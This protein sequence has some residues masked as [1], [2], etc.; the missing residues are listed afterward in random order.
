VIVVVAVAVV[1]ALLVLA[2][3]V[4]RHDRRQGRERRSARLMSQE[5]G[6]AKRDAR[7]KLAM[8]N[9]AATGPRL[10]KARPRRK[11]RP[12]R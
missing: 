2:Y 8:R 10:R 9:A 1:A 7:A 11:Q 5:I 6:A 3:F 12:K 4:D